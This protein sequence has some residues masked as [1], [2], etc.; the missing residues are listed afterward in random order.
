MR[1]D[2]CLIYSNDYFATG[3]SFI[4]CITEECLRYFS[5]IEEVR[6]FVC[7]LFVDSSSVSVSVPHVSTLHILLCA[8]FTF[9]SQDTT[10]NS[11]YLLCN[12]LQLGTCTTSTF[13]LGWPELQICEQPHDFNSKTRRWK[14]ERRQSAVIE[15]EKGFSNGFL[16]GPAVPRS[17][18]FAGTLRP[19]TADI[20]QIR[21]TV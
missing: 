16:V 19:K 8:P 1:D 5:S 2:K 7:L 9:A 10:Y 17:T 13:S 14:L 3:D 18:L 4:V 11:L 6:S 20:Q 12:V 21:V 15:T